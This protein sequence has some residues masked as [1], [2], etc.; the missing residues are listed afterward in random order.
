MSVKSQLEEAVK[1]VRSTCFI[2]A[3]NKIED[4]IKTGRWSSQILNR[5]NP[6]KF[7]KQNNKWNYRIND[8]TRQNFVYDLKI[9][10]SQNDPLNDPK[11]KLSN[12][13]RQL[14]LE[15]IAA[16]KLKAANCG[17][18]AYLIAKY[19]WEHHKGIDKIEL[20]S[21][22]NYDH[23]FV[24]VNRP[25]NSDLNDSTTWGSTTW[26]VDAWH[27]D[28]VAFPATEFLTWIKQFII[29]ATAQAS[30]LQTENINWNPHISK[31]TDFTLK[32]LHTIFPQK[33]PYPIYQPEKRL[34]DYYDVDVYV[35][36]KYN[37][38]NEQ[39]HFG[40]CLTEIKQYAAMKMIF[41]NNMAAKYMTA[42]YA[43][44]NKELS[45]TEKEQRNWLI[46]KMDA[47]FSHTAN[48]INL[49]HTS[50]ALSIAETAAAGING[51]S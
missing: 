10:S 12:A 51:D 41:T 5:A 25:D 4:V 9:K 26:C 35:P 8:Y 3:G 39:T 6:G 44:P 18:R 49:L 45:D 24:I 16:Q 11:F 13:N 37:H 40:R 29:F 17:A 43:I 7:V 23:A 28:G 1:F 21:F 30:S 50:K 14:L 48:K 31:K 20:V 2:G 15:A 32:T 38:F 34:E 27:Q 33:D 42:L 22:N 47:L 46:G 36:T 19:L